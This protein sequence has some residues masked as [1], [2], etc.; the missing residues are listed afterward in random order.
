MQKFFTLLLISLFLTQ[1]GNAQVT[2]CAT[3]E[4]EAA[5]KA[6]YPDYEQRKQEIEAYTNRYIQKNK[7]QNKMEGG[8]T[9]KIPIVFHIV[10]K[11]AAQNISDAR[12][13]EQIDI[14]NADFRRLNADTTDTPDEFGDVAADCNVEF[15]LA[16]ID[17]D[18]NPT[19]GILRVETDVTT[20]DFDDGIKFTA[21]GGSDAW[22]ADEYLNF[23]SGNIG[24]F[25]LGYAQFPGGPAATD[26]VVIHYQH[27]GLEP[28]GYPYH[29]GR[30]ATHEV[31][32]WLNLYHIWG[33]DGGCAGSDLCG[34]T[35]N[36]KVETYGCPGFPKTDIC[37]PD[38]PGIM[39]QNYMDYTDD[40]CMNIFTQDQKDRIQSLF[41]PGGE[42]FNLTNSEGCGLQPYDAQAITAL[43]GGTI[44]DL[45]V[46][47]VVTIKNHGTVLL[48][49][50]D[51]LYNI[52]GGPTSTYNWTGSLVTG[53]TE[54]VSLP[55]ITTTEGE[56]TLEAT[57]ENPNGFDDADA[58][59]NT[60]ETDFLVSLTA[61]PLPLSQGFEASGFP[62]DGYTINNPD[63]YY[64]WERTNDAAA[65]GTYSI[66][67]NHFDNDANGEIDEFVIP[68]YDLSGM[69]TINFTFDVAYALY[70]NGGVYS[71]TL[72]VLVSD[73]CGTSWESVYKKANP[74]LQ[75][76]PF[77][78]SSFVP[79]DDEWRN[80]VIDLT[81][82]L[83]SSQLFV[84]FRTISD[85]ENNLYVDNINLNDGQQIGVINTSN[86]F[87]LSLFPNPAN[88][89]LNI[90]Y[91]IA[92]TGNGTLLIYDVLGKLVFSEIIA[93]TSGINIITIPV[94]DL[95]A[96]YYRIKLETG[97]MNAS[98]PFVKE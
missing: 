33:D 31:G 88:D 59:D 97:G 15:C 12:I 77:T 90:K 10:Y 54:A 37:S 87:K 96:G 82:Y 47:P 63:D 89:L 86:D 91:N 73:N 53:A 34:D 84:K 28:A 72:E 24:A 32:H 70:T 56:H 51:I 69:A 66:Y 75:T 27:V 76:A 3:V 1:A 67:M 9:I 92:Q 52:D 49:S 2:R 5:L 42:R 60:A 11:T 71:D 43:P 41:E 58:G 40:A 22:P 74:D 95:S 85:Y 44:C 16:V 21:D 38:D 94:K 45:T 8:V 20:F 25:L 98:T 17:P 39:F 93:T 48:T 23:W 7:S 19:T 30:T 26:G 81:S 83:G 13:M 55:A 78:A 36:Q 64:T 6:K 68:A 14:L 35:P 46:N 65:L 57:L 62:Y 50:I 4:H 61:L 80:E 29:L 79:E 18:G